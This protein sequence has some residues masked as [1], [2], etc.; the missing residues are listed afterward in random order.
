MHFEI[1]I[2]GCGAGLPTLQRHASA[3]VIN[4]RENYLLVDC[5]ESTQLQMR[6]YG[7]R[8]Q[9]IDHIF[10]SH[11]HGDHY[12]GLPGLLFSMHLLGRTRALN[13]YAHAKLMDIIKLNCEVSETRLQFKINFHELNNEV[14][15]LL[16]ENKSFQVYSFPLKHRIA[17]CGFIFKEKIRSRHINKA[18]VNKYNI[19]TTWMQRLKDGEDYVSESGEIIPNKELTTK[20][21]KVF[22]YAYCSDTKYSESLLEYI[23]DA[24]A[25]Y[26][27]A[28]F[29]NDKKDRAKDTYH[30]TAEQAAKLAKLAGVQKLIIGHFSARYRNENELLHEA[31]QVFKNTVTASDGLVIQLY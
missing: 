17:C 9:R 13:I 28:T 22:S 29:A 6:K 1:T 31:I 11:L 3:Q 30:S 16:F 15:N 5:G 18:R 25:L 24:D 20:P 27:E 4:I 8:Y 10:I 19:P 2:L 7:I 12:L 21:D 26:H 23:K 14:Q